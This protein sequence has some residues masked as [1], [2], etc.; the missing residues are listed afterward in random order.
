MAGAAGA[1]AAGAGASSIGTAAAATDGRFGACE[2]R[3]R[4]AMGAGPVAPDAAD[5]AA[6]AVVSALV[7]SNAVGDLLSPA[8]AA[9]AGEAAAGAGFST[10]WRQMQRRSFH[11]KHVRTP[12]NSVSSKG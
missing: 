8:A 4:S 1:A 7:A 6:M 12:V 10:W 9:G 11:M 3:S 2:P 5:F